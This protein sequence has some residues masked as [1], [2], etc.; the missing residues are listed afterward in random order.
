MST[1][2]RN[3]PC[4]CGSGQKY[5]KCCGKNIKKIP[6]TGKAKE[7]FERQLERF[8][9]KFGRDPGPNDPVFFDMDANA[10]VPIAEEKLNEGIAEAMKKAGVPPQYIYAWIQ[11]G[12]LVTEQNYSQWS[13]ADLKEWEEAINGYYANP[14]RN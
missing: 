1:P 3:D 13:K 9:E 2:G 12:M 10:P 4:P 11:T 7:A 6:I 14:E 8:R 5:K